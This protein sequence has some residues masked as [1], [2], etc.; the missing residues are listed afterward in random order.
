MAEPSKILVIKLGA[1]G[2]F[3]QA[4]GPMAAIRKQHPGAHITLL[5]TNSFRKFAER[6]GYF[7]EIWMDEKP[8]ML[9]IGGWVNLRGKLNNAKFDRV[10]D[11]QNNDRTSFY[12]RLFGRK[13]EWVGVA[14]GAS[15]RNDSPERTKGHAFD[16]HVQTLGLTG[17]QNIEVDDLSWIKEDLSG[18]ALERSYV[19]L[20]P[21]CAPEHPYKR[22]PAKKYTQ[23]AK[24]IGA[25]GYQ[26]VLL[27]TQDEAEINREIANA[28]SMALD[29]TGQ[30]SLFQIA[31]LAQGAAA[32][33]GNDTGPMHI[34]AATGCPSLVLFS[35][36][37]N[38]LRHAPKANAVDYLQEASLEN[39]SV[40]AVLGKFRPRFEPHKIRLTVH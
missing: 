38:P 7:N 3:I 14:K 32:A 25:W 21:G 27:G 1:L 8:G 17:I 24:F 28:C 20:V 40:E 10:Y 19:L 26:P 13:P 15:H 23:F 29:L 5:T 12:F 36:H 2:D 35:A 34:I 39:L 33:V 9:N 4:L 31:A 18:F 16:G 11:L 30:T 6:S 22:W 37:S